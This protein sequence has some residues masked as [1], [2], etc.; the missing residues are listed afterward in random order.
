[1]DQRHM[2]TR[3][4]LNELSELHREAAERLAALEQRYTGGRRDL[5]AALATSRRPLSVPEI[6]E[7]AGE[8]PQSS[9]YRHLSVLIEAGVVARVATGSDQARFELSE[10]LSG[11]HHH[12]LVCGSCG[13]VVDVDAFPRLERAL[14]AAARV[15]EEES[16]FEV[17]GHKIDLVG[18]CTACRL[19]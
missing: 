17:T 6:L 10:R 19:A 3:S 1:M 5:V 14:D 7:V 13:T 8:I 16:G 11:E 18:R 4:E 12:H 15:A 2:T 9:A